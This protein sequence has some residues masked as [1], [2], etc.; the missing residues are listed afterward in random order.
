MAELCPVSPSES[1]VWFHRIKA[2]TR[3]LVKVCGG[4]VR[5]GEIANLSKSEMS[6]FQSAVDPDIITVPAVLALEG[7]CKLPLVTTVMADLRGHRLT[8][9]EG[10]TAATIRLMRS[11][12]D[13]VR[14]AAEMMAAGAAAMADGQLTPSEIELL[15]RS[16][17]ELERALAATRLDI[18]AAKAGRFRV[19]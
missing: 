2:A 15:D 19:V 7:E 14:A 10:E 13:T 9:S 18:A 3:D 16:A 12:A 1:D 17:G 4:V 5:A 8:S 6:R 11:H